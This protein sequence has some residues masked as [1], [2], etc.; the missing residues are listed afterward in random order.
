M[1]DP[2]MLPFWRFLEEFNGF[3]DAEELTQKKGTNPRF[4]SVWH[5]KAITETY[6]CL[7]R[8]GST[9]RLKS[10]L[11]S[12]LNPGRHVDLETNSSQGATLELQHT[13]YH[14]DH[15]EQIVVYISIL[16]LQCVA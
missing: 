9:I 2:N 5:L 3:F 1:N 12:I 4:V 13:H 16:I 8:D 6:T 10:Q 7:E 14:L 15:R 11:L